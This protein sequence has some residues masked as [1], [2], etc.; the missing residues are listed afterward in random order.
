MMRMGNS[1]PAPSVSTTRSRPSGRTIGKRRS[2]SSSGMSRNPIPIA[3]SER[4]MPACQP[5][6]CRRK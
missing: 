4:D 1:I 5:L 2:A 3:P 6:S